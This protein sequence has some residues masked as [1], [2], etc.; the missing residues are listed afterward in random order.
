MSVLFL[1]LA[2]CSAGV[3]AFSN[4]TPFQQHLHQQVVKPRNR[5][6]VSKT[7]YLYAS[8][9]TH[10]ESSNRFLTNHQSWGGESQ[11]DEL[12]LSLGATTD[13]NS[14]SS[15]SI[16]AMLL[17][18]PATA[19]IIAFPE[20][21][22]AADSSAGPIPSA[23]FAWF[24]YVGIMGVSGGLMTERFL[25][26]YN[27]NEE[28]EIKV[29]NADGIYGLSAF[30]LLI[31]GY[32]RVTQYAKGFDFYKNEP[33]FWLKM[34]S[35]A[36]LGGLSFYPA[37]IFFRRDQARRNGMT[38]SPLSDAIVDRITTILNAEILAV[39]SIPFMATLMAR[40]VWYVNDFPWAIGVILYALSLG[41]AGYKYGKGAFDMMEEENALVPVEGES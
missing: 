23:A 7:R 39:A 29:N 18:L 13:A 24:H 20:T 15:I 36:V 3:N 35:I 6:V 8:S 10:T 33:I 5:L 40:G 19:T 17:L 16:F 41:G 9:H 31:S 26:K 21:A 30:S 38:L 4:L 28:E 1:C 32:F 11:V 12:Q 25:I 27:M 22:V 34:A 37:I 14:P 2:W